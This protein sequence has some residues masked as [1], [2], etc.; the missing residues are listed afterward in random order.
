L[1][2]EA[3]R[4]YHARFHPAITLS[5]WFDSFVMAKKTGMEASRGAF[6]PFNMRREFATSD[7]E[8]I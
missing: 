8:G 6:G 4:A 2:L 3:E 7:Y 5:F 1:Q